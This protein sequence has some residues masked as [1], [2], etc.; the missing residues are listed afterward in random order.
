MTQSQDL[1]LTGKAAIVTGGTRGIG[2]AIASSLCRAGAAVVICGRDPE[3][4]QKATTEISS[5]TGA[6]IPGAAADVAD[7]HDVAA[8]FEFA[9]QQIGGLDI[10]VNNAG[11]GIF[12]SVADLTLEDWRHTIDTNL[13]GTYLC[14]H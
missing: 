8:L 14:S 4:V 10:L 1:F 7:A 3:H 12:K 13:T 11:I 9:D 6:R 2:R 5:D